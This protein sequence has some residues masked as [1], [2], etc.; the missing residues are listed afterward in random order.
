MLS[1]TE[2]PI[3]LSVFKSKVYGMASM[4]GLYG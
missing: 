3:E 2:L 4:N 1:R